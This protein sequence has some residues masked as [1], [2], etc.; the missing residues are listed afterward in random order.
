MHKPSLISLEHLMAEWPE[1]FDS[2][3]KN[4]LLIEYL[5]SIRL[6]FKNGSLWEIDIDRY[7]LQST[8][9]A[10]KIKSIVKEYKTEIVR[11]DFSIDIDKL[12]KDTTLMI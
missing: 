3:Y 10:E 7:N 11:L 8:S 6:E 5:M 4:F 1:V 12:K 9:T 2:F